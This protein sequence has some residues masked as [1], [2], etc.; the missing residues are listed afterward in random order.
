M[1]ATN[2]D[3]SSDVMARI[4]DLKTEVVE[5]CGFDIIDKEGV[6]QL[7]H[8]QPLAKQKY[9]TPLLIVYA[10]INR[11]YVLD[12][13]PETSVIQKYLMAGFDVYMIDWG[14]P[15]AADQFLNLDDYVDYIDRSVERIKSLTGVDRINLHGYC[16]GGTLSAIYTA[17]R[18]KNIKNLVLQAAPIDFHTDNIVALTPL[19]TPITWRRAIFWLPVFFW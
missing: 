2:I 4:A 10:F 12:F 15:T 17:L 6:F 1:A 5:S 7:R 18:Q 14:Y 13:Q 9:A 16:L 19:L 3:F 8:Y 11:P